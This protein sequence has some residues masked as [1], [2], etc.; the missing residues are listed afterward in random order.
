MPQSILTSVSSRDV[1]TTSSL[2]GTW[3]SISSE[4]LS[5]GRTWRRTTRRISTRELWRRNFQLVSM[6]SARGSRVSS[7]PTSPIAEI[8]ASMRNL[9]TPT[10]ERFSRISSREVATSKI[11]SMT[12]ILLL[13]KKRKRMARMDRASPRFRPVP[14]LI[15]S[16]NQTRILMT[17]RSSENIY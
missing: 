11:M 5:P 3:C 9:I 6:F 2:S 7:E 12:G 10:S 14:T 17:L 8:S 15:P 13:R 16:T 1:E 4:D